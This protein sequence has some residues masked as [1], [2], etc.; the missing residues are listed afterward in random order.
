VGNLGRPFA[1]RDTATVDEAVAAVASFV[2]P[3]DVYTSHSTPA[4]EHGPHTAHAENSA[5]ADAV[6]GMREATGV[7]AK[8]GTPPMTEPVPDPVISL[9]SSDGGGGVE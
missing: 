1:T 6:G 2:P 3:P 4:G 9:C 7:T 8:P 5:H